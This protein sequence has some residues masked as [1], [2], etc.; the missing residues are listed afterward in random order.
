[1]SWPFFH[2]WQGAEPVYLQE[3]P[4]DLAALVARVA[5]DDR[6]GIACF[7]GNVRDHHGGRAVRRLEYSAYPAMAEAECARIVA[8]AEHR[9][10]VA[11][12]L[13]HRIGRLGIGEAAVAVAAA[14][15]HRQEALDACRHVVEEVKRRVPIW[16]R[17]FYTDG[18]VLWVDPTAAQTN[19]PT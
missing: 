8:A 14:S 12:A 17:E 2:R 4:L 7:I 15:A 5:A 11:V 16:K 9:W 3:T 13:A 19:L 1:M 6:G 18:T 10:P